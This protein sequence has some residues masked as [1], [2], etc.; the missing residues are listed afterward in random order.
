MEPFSLRVMRMRSTVVLSACMARVPIHLPVSTTAACHLSVI[1]FWAAMGR[2]E[3]GR[4]G[5]GMGAM[6]VSNGDGVRVGGKVVMEAGG[7]GRRGKGDGHVVLRLMMVLMG[8][9]VRP[10]LGL[11]I[12]RPVAMFDLHQ[13]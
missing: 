10:G 12:F 13:G 5:V 11:C 2:P 8:L 6:G 4:L 1:C 3:G 7:V 9:L